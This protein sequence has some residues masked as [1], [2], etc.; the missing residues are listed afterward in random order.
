MADDR[1]ICFIQPLKLT[2]EVG[3]GKQKFQNFSTK[4]QNAPMDPFIKKAPGEKTVAKTTAPSTNREFS[5]NG[6]QPAR[7]YRNWFGAKSPPLPKQ[8]GL[9]RY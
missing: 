9:V 2:L 4:P 5:S 6:H 7:N 3:G 1:G 8:G